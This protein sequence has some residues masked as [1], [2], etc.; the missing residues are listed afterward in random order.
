MTRRPQGAQRDQMRE[1]TFPLSSTSYTSTASRSL[2]QA[3]T[4]SAAPSAA[5][6]TTTA[7]RAPTS[8]LDRLRG[9]SPACRRRS[10]MTQSEDDRYKVVLDSLSRRRPLVQ[11]C[12]LD[13]RL[14]KRVPLQDLAAGV[15]LSSASSYP[16]KGRAS[17]SDIAPW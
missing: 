1:C 11:T 2:T 4:R 3:G 14:S 12:P 5:V 9:S 15:S 10:P 6:G 7:Y 16:R 8:T 13:P 17:Q